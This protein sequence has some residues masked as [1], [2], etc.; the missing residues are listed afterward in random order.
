MREMELF[1][2]SQLPMLKSNAVIVYRLIS[3]F[4]V[5]LYK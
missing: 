5:F 1:M 4:K 3:K 2:M